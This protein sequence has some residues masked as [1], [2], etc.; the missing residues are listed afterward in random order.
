MAEWAVEPM[1]SVLA[2]ETEADQDDDD[3]TLAGFAK[4]F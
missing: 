3:M 2:S 4:S 1:Q